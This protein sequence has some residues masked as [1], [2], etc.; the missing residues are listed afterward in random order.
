MAKLSSQLCGDFQLGD[1][2]PVTPLPFEDQPNTQ[3][4]QT[5][6]RNN[7]QGKQTS[8]P[9]AM[10]YTHMDCYTVHWCGN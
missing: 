5:G 6:L 4:H 10:V 9:L 8:E 7:P 1:I 3:T 2:C